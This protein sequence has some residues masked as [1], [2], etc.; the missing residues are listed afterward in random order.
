MIKKSTRILVLVV[1]MLTV[2]AVVALALAASGGPGN[3][4]T[5]KN[6]KDTLAE[7][8]NVSNTTTTSSNGTNVKISPK[9]AQKIAKS[10]I[11]ESG[12]T[13][14]TPQ[15]DEINGQMVYNVPVIINGTNVG[16]I[17]INAMT[18]ENMG[19]AGGAP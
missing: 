3:N 18:G 12:A 4:T 7:Q 17:T 16:E 15:L 14:G 6:K 1:V 8:K 10:F 5:D 13:A 11:K 19:G 2:L 9:E